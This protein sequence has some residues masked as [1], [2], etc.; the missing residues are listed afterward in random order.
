[1][2]PPGF[3]LHRPVHPSALIPHP[4]FL[5]STFHDELG[6]SLVT[7]CLVTLGR[8]SP[9]ADRMTAARRFSFTAAERMVDGVHGHA[10]VVGH[11]AEVTG[12][13]RFADGDVFVLEV[14]DAA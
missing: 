7:A 9:R 8:L 4:L 14:P 13:P 6:G 5:A 11:L 12:A 2:K 10:A 3:V 1:M